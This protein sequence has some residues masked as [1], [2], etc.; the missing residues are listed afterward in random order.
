MISFTNT[1]IMSEHIKQDVGF[2]RCGVTAT[3]EHMSAIR[4]TTAQLYQGALKLKPNQILDQKPTSN[5]QKKT[6]DV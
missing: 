4:K 2:V 1:Q 3:V 5:I 6:N